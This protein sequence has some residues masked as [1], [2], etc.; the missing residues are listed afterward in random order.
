MKP[1]RFKGISTALTVAVIATAAF[2]QTS[3][4]KNAEPKH[5]VILF[6][7]DGLRHGSVN[8]ADAPTLYAL[9]QLGVHFVNSHSIFPTF[10]TANA[11]VMATGH[12]LG[13]TGDF[14]NTLHPGYA[15]FNTGNFGKP[16]GTL[17]PFVENNQVLADLD[18]HFNGNYLNEETILSLARKNGYNTAAIGKVGP[19]AIFDV[20]QLEPSGKAFQLPMTVIIDDATGTAAGVPLPADILSALTAAGLPTVAPN[21]TNG[22]LP[23]SQQSNGFSGNNV[24]PGTL[25]PNIVQQQYFVDAMTKAV[26]PTFVANGQPF[27]AVYWSRDPD[28]TQHN[29]GDSLNSLTPGINGPTSKA[30]VKNADNNLKQILEFFQANPSLIPTTDLIVTS[31][32]GFSTISKHEV[33]ASLN[34]FVNDYASKFIY[35]D[36]TGRQEV[37]T[38]F[39]PVGFLA[40]DIAHH[41]GLPLYD[42]DNQVV[43]TDGVTPMYEPVDPTIAQQTATVRQHSA[44]GNGVIGGTGQ[45]PQTGESKDAKIL[46]AANGGSDLI[47]VPDHNAATVKALVAYLRNQNYTGGLFVDDDFGTIPGALPMST[48]GLKGSSPL[49]TP[50]I[51]INFKNFALD[52]RNPNQ[53]RVE[54][55]DSGLQEGQGMHGSFSRADTFN[56]MLAY[57][58]DFKQHYGDSE[59]VS[60]ADIAWT[61]ARI[62][63]LDLPENGHLTGRLL[64]EALAGNHS[65]GNDL[66]YYIHKSTVGDGKR[67][68]LVTQYYSNTRYYDSACLVSAKPGER[69]GDFDELSKTNPCN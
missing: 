42:P 59:P 9:R 57:G 66:L 8:P 11:S 1:S 35:K 2:A 68:V 48:I 63:K 46:V 30:A 27:I 60:N 69:S 3:Q 5:N 22:A 39:L 29:Q 33:D 67:T 32:H 31:D 7:A 54:I 20:S 21:R 24:T 55:A 44:S 50:A 65:N 34:H 19:A 51:A 6:V 25:A 37:N 56:N 36:A 15:I 40:I 14:S 17:T 41:L 28:G 58:V 52:A 12:L 16:T 53:T 10:T 43:G 47:Y 49:P 26:L 45:I 13:D 64:S 61:I 18:D 4:S 23:T 62:L 38:G